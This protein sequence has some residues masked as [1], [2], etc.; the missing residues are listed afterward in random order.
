MWDVRVR[1][2]PVN[3]DARRDIDVRFLLLPFFFQTI[4]TAQDLQTTWPDEEIAERLR[5]YLVWAGP[6]LG[7]AN[8]DP[9]L[10]SLRD[11]VVRSANTL[12]NRMG[13]WAAARRGRDEHWVHRSYRSFIGAI[14]GLV[15]LMDRTQTYMI[16]DDGPH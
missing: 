10:E 1:T 2:D 12:A 6:R 7:A 8:V 11:A 5:D 9:E 4:E 16:D 15:T 13:Q 14:R 3:G